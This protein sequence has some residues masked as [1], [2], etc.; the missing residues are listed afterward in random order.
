MS[1]RLS[2]LLSESNGSVSN[3]SQISPRIAPMI[4]PRF[5]R[6]ACR[7]AASRRHVS[8]CSDGGRLLRLG[9]TAWGGPRSRLTSARVCVGLSSVA[10]T[11]GSSYGT[12]CSS[13]GETGRCRS[14]E[15]RATGSMVLQSSPASSVQR[16]RAELECSVSYHDGERH[17]DAS[18]SQRRQ[19]DVD[20]TS[21]AGDIGSV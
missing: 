8:S 4:L 7:V 9:R 6:N 17:R 21:L 1:I 18:K 16:A 5:S 10:S 13:W 12:A 15:T 3:L 20:V 14:L 2:K 19:Q 11:P